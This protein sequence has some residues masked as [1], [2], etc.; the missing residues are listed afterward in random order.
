[1]EAVNKLGILMTLRRLRLIDFST[2]GFTNTY[3]FGVYDTNLFY[4]GKLGG[5]H[6]YIHYIL[7]ANY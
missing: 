1:M 7:Q 5:A 2:K 6:K 4:V 3:T